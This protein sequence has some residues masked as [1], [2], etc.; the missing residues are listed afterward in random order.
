MTAFPDLK[1]SMNDLIPRGSRVEYHWTL[2]GTNT[3]PGGTGK[4]VHI[5]GYEEW[6]LGADGLVEDSLGQFDATDY[7]RQLHHVPPN[8]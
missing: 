1:L 6:R 5:T 4:K 7:E 3:G 8:P 2:E